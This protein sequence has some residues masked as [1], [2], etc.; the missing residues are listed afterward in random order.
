M[1]EGPFRTAVKA[2]VRIDFSLVPVSQSFRHAQISLPVKGFWE[3][4][5]FLNLFYFIFINLHEVQ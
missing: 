2:E 3:Q 5:K 4:L 1:K